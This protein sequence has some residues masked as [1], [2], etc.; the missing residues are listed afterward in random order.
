MIPERA[1]A[2]TQTHAIVIDEVFPHA[3]AKVWSALTDGTLL[4]RWLMPATG[5]RAEVGTRFTFSTRAEGLWDG[6]IRCEVLEVLREQRLA[7]SW[8]GGHPDNSGYGSDLDTVVTW[9]LS[10]EGSG[11][12]VRLIHSGFVLPRNVVAHS[13]MSEGWKVVI[14]RLSGLAGGEH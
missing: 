13:N 8:V 1:E 5:F 6:T 9:L 14:K 2:Q 4:S 7:Y 11:T 12:R 3:P 10:V